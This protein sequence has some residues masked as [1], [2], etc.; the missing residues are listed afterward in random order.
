MNPSGLSS[1]LNERSKLHHSTP[2]RQPSHDRPSSHHGSSNLEPQRMLPPI[3]DLQ[4][5]GNDFRGHRP[6]YNSRQEADGRYS[7]G[8]LLHSAPGV[9]TSVPRSAEQARPYSVSGTSSPFA[10]PPRHPCATEQEYVP[11]QFVTTVNPQNGALNGD[12]G[13][14]RGRRRRGNLPK[15]VTDVL[16][17]WIADHLDNPYP[18]DEDKQMLIAH[19]GLTSSQVR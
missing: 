14:S 5:R 19:T 12:P 6:G 15:A 8:Q 1:V 9:P 10:S 11:R 17:Q 18:S 13:D 16:R 3:R 2:P 7:P 4:A